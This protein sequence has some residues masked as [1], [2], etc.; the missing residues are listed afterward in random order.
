MPETADSPG[1]HLL[2]LMPP[3]STLAIEHPEFSNGEDYFV[4]SGTSQAAAVVSGAAVLLLDWDPALSPDDP[5]AQA[6][7]LTRV[8]R[9]RYY[10]LRRRLEKD[11]GAVDYSDLS[12]EPVSDEELTELEM[13]QVTEAA[14]AA[15]QKAQQ[16]LVRIGAG[17]G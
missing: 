16:K 11:P 4:M 8:R 14:Q 9:L 15:S 13:F 2:G 12:L 6:R 5:K 7:A 3:N 10:P 17:R 1:G